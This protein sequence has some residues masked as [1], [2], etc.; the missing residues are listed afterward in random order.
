[1]QTNDM[2]VI[3]R[4]N[5]WTLTDKKENKDFKIRVVAHLP[6]PVHG[7]TPTQAKELLFYEN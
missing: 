2:T 1:M 5:N 7:P 6:A 3:Q 4:Q